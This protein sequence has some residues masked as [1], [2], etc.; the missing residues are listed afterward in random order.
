MV[1]Y[2]QTNKHWHKQPPRRRKY[3][4]WVEWIEW[5]QSKP[6]QWS[7]SFSAWNLQGSKTGA[8]LV[9][10]LLATAMMPFLPPRWRPSS[11]HIW[12]TSVGFK[13]APYLVTTDPDVISSTG[14]CANSVINSHCCGFFNFNGQS[15]CSPVADSQLSYH[16]FSRL[17]TWLT[18]IR[19]RPERRHWRKSTFTFWSRSS[20]RCCW[21]VIL[22]SAAEAQLSR[23]C[24]QTWPHLSRWNNH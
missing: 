9:F 24:C 3:W 4:T 18:F 22:C 16:R 15:F 19:S 1:K 8:W 13:V 5:K 6:F 7:S 20:W 2:R 23:A 14:S 11:F 10:T 17:K 21:E 12:F